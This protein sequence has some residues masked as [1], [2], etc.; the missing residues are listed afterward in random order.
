MLTL[1][2]ALITAKNQLSQSDPWLLL[3]IVELVPSTTYLYLVRN[4]EDVTFNSQ[5]YTAFPFEIEAVQQKAKGEAPVVELRVSNVSRAIQAYVE[6][7]NGL[8][9][10]QITLQLVNAGLLTENYA[11]LTEYFCVLGCVCNVEWV[12][13]SLGAPRV[14]RRRFPLYRYI[15]D[16]CAY[17]QYFKGA[18]CKYA[19][20]LTTCNGTIAD[21]TIR[22]NTANFGG[23]YGLSKGGV[24]LA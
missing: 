18:E 19:G 10:N 20:V 13:F 7:Y 3:I 16:H 2:A 8:V 14:L 23:F 17:V 9:G 15:S 11:E 21:C 5:V 22:S 1:P 4:T 24:K 6:Q 12:T